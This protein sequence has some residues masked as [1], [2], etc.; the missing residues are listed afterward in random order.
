MDVEGF[1]CCHVCGLTFDDPI[2]L[3]DHVAIFH[4]N[5]RSSIFRFAPA[6][7]TLQNSTDTQNT[8]CAVEVSR[9]FKNALVRHFQIENITDSSFD[10]F[11]ANVRPLVEETVKKEV[12][13]LNLIV[14]GIVLETLFKNVEDVVSPRAFITRNRTVYETSDLDD[15]LNEM[16]QELLLK[17]TEHE[18]RGSG[19]SLHKIVRICI[20]SHKK[21]YGDRGSSYISLPSKIR[22]TK[23]CINV[24]NIDNECFKYAMLAKFLVGENNSTRPGGHY[25]ALATRYNFT[26]L[27][28]PVSLNGVRQFEIRNPGV[29]VNVFGLDEKENIYPVKV[30]NIEL[31]NHTDLLL[32]K[33]GDNSHYVYIKDFNSL[34]KKQLNCH[35][36][37]ITVCKKCF[38]FKS[39]TGARGKTW[40]REHQ[41]LC[42]KH[43]EVIV[44]L[45]KPENAF[46]SFC[47]PSY[48][49][50]VPIVVYADFEAL[51]LPVKRCDLAPE[52][53]KFT[54]KIQKHEPSSYCML[55]KSYLPNTLLSSYNIS[56]TPKVY[57]GEDAAQQFVNDLHELAGKV[58]MLYKREIPMAPMTRDEKISYEAATTCCLCKMLFTQGNYKVRDHD[59][60]TGL[61]RGPTCNV[62]NI[63][64]KVPRF[65]PVVMHNLSKYDCHFI[66]PELAKDRNK[67]DV[68]ATTTENFISFSK[69]V[70]KVTLRFVDSYRFMAASLDELTKNLV[71]ENVDD[72][73]ETRKLV[74]VDKMPLVLRKGVFPYEYI[75]SH[76]TFKETALPPKESFYSSLTESHISEED[77][78]HAL[79]VW[80]ELHMGTLGEYSDFYVT[81]DVTLLCDIMEKFRTTCIIAYGL[82]ALHFLTAPGL[83]WQAM[84]KETRCK[85]DLIT[86]SDMLLMVES[87]IRGGLTQCVK[88]YVKANN[89]DMDEFDPSKESNYIAYYD[90]NN[91]YGWA[92]SKQLPL[93]EFTWVNPPSI[94]DIIAL[95]E[96]ADFGYILECDIEYP[97]YLH[98]LHLDL[99]L[100]PV[101]EIPPNA[102]FPKLLTTLH[103][104]TK[105]VAHYS[106]IK[107]AIK[108]GV[109][110]VNINRAIRF[111][112]SCWLK[113]YIDKNT[114][115]R[116][117][118]TTA[119]EQDFFK[120]MNNAVF[121]KTLENK[122][123]HMDVRLVS[124][125][126]ELTKLTSR[127]NFKTSIVVNENLVLVNM[128]KTRVLMNRP[129]Y[130]GM[131]ILDI[132]KTHMYDFHYNVMIPHF[133]RDNLTIAYMDTDAYVYDIHTPDLYKKLEEIK[134]K[135]DFSAYPK[136][137]SSAL[138][139]VS[140]K[141][142]LGKFKDE[143]NGA[144]I[145]E[146]VGL[147]AK[148]YALRLS[149]PGEKSVK[150]KAKGVKTGYLNKHIT[151]DH[152]KTSL[153]EDATFYAEF[154]T[155]RSYNQSLFTIKQ[156]KKSISF[157]DDKRFILP[158]K[159][160]T[161]P[162][163]HKSLL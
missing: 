7:E 31:S 160:N 46:V 115:R 29:S 132:S 125:E 21:G 133:G 110:V 78:N 64:Y 92:M 136:D 70:G 57:R 8:F 77:Y 100:L 1:I 106:I 120:L 60:L 12:S 38:T 127:A 91:L 138:Y 111:K 155:I 23:S 104:K 53:E 89:K 140:N 3:N 118:S 87:G 16:F 2:I 42:G 15:I 47:K 17:I 141:K 162:H 39:I 40:L 105:Y 52:I 43:Q 35:H 84:L 22:N 68:I 50:R 93:G 33:D 117:Q 54:E 59:H 158:D 95:D 66:I 28:Y 56:S 126:N 51:L 142:V 101:N 129:L 124:D 131:A 152:Y 32:I 148:M 137:H 96:N 11:T 119:F 79:L 85:L 108:L 149:I 26:G 94:N 116:A 80:H 13:R 86:D 139:D 135:F 61:Y 73:I 44:S 82:D 37:R 9:A 150:K 6:D 151:F 45:P 36:Q 49:Y 128:R 20:R 5:V 102:K 34:I 10:E 114:E 123:K 154:S 144:T 134:D 24:Q 161:I 107:Q 41:R 146:F 74:S 147:M 103:N 18:A 98:D 4:P 72:L 71:K 27:E 88:R 159:I 55:I 14:F 109:R 83:S 97:E 75:T 76:S 69:K 63:N 130:I 163:G 156:K 67:V 153:F 58:E 113:P 121:G 112:Q 90:A 65:I 145:I 62:C 99:P 48:Q 19:W 122:R 81:L 30:V 25:A 157:H 143:V